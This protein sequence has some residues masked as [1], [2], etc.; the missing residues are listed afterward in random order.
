[1][2]EYALLGAQAAGLVGDIFTRQSSK[3][4]EQQLDLRIKQERIASQEQSLFNLEQLAETLATQRA[5][6]AVRG[7]TPGIGSAASL[8]SKAIG[9]F[10]RD[11]EARTLSLEFSEQN[12]RAQI[13]VGRVA[14]YGKQAQ[15]ASALFGKAFNMIPFAEYGQSNTKVKTG[16]TVP[17]YDFNSS[18]AN[19]G[20]KTGLLTG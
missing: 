18:L 20:K 3:L 5:L 13:A 8:E 12:R 9:R 11:E 19:Y 4:E 7:A 10:N 2:L 16:S 14:L 6:M 1:M 15:G 17:K